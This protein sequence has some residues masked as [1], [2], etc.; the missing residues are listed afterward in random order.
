MGSRDIT[1]ALAGTRT[2]GQDGGGRGVEW[3]R[4]DKCVR[5]CWRRQR[6]V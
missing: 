5:G 4:R 1:T 2:R 6:R 3:D